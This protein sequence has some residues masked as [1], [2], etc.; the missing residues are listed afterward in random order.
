MGLFDWLSEGL[1]SLS[2]DGSSMMGQPKPPQVDTVL[3]QQSAPPLQPPQAPD[4]PY[5]AMPGGGP[6]GNPSPVPLPQPRPPGADAGASLP[7]LPTGNVPDAP[8]PMDA[9]QSPTDISAQSVAPV[10]MPPGTPPGGGLPMPGAPQQQ[11]TGSSFL[12]RALGLSP[13][14]DHTFRAKLGAGLKS[15]GDNYTKPGLAAFAGSAGASIKGGTD[16]EDKLFDQ[17]NK[18]LSNMIAAKAKGNTEEYT[19]AQAAYLRAKI[20]I[21][22]RKAADPN[23]AKG[24]MTPEQRMVTVQKLI[25][26]DQQIRAQ[27]D[28]L[29][30]A[31]LPKDKQAAEAKL[32]ALVDSKKKEFEDRLTPGSQTNP[33]KPTSMDDAKGYQPGQFFINPADGKLYRYKGAPDKAA[34]PSPAEDAVTG[35]PTAK[36]E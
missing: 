27:R 32:N 20:E 10:P 22:R 17:R 23:A 14:D 30:T 8:A 2:V 33:L 34:T 28:L 19:K 13:Q 31:V 26:G 35:A 1:G 21:E 18:A 11:P 36:D 4:S 9:G 12:G 6:D 16:A 25:N 24:A 7:P 5:A 15:V 29:R 3:P